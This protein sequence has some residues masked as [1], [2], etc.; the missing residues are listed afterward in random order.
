MVRSSPVPGSRYPRVAFNHRCLFLNW[1][2]QN[3]LLD[4]FVS[5]LYS[6]CDVHSIFLPICCV[7]PIF[8]LDI[9]GTEHGLI[10]CWSIFLGLHYQLRLEDTAKRL[11]GS[12]DTPPNAIFTAII[13][14]HFITLF[15]ASKSP[16]VHANFSGG[17]TKS[18]PPPSS[19]S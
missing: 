12:E 5:T 15:F 11:D 16:V 14:C 10:F 6:L 18:L 1:P 9:F 17:D 13:A 8:F 19:R 4:D 3:R 2:C 7:R